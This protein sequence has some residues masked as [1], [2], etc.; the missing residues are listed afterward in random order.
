MVAFSF[1]SFAVVFVQ[2]LTL[3]HGIVHRVRINSFIFYFWL[4]AY[5]GERLAIIE[6]FE[7]DSA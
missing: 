5:L 4:H 7:R 2:V 3:G 1:F 6:Y